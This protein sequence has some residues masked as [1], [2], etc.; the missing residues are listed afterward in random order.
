[1]NAAGDALGPSPIAGRY[2]HPHREE[3]GRPVVAEHYANI[4]RL[5]LGGDVLVAQGLPEHL[6]KEAAAYLAQGDKTILAG[7]GFETVRLFLRIDHRY[8]AVGARR[9]AVGQ[10]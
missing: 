8:S 10:L 6:C 4:I 3:R 1:M 9:D 2:E 5:K 7:L